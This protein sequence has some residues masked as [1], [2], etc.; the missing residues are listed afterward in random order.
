M[1][2][3]YV[4][5]HAVV[6]DMHG[7][8][9]VLHVGVALRAAHYGGDSLHREHVTIS[10]AVV[11]LIAQV[12]IVVKLL[13]CRGRHLACLIR[14]AVLEVLY[15][16]GLQYD[17][18]GGEALLAVYHLVLAL[19]ALVCHQRA[20]VVRA[21]GMLSEGVVHVLYQCRNLVLLPCVVALIYGYGVCL[22]VLALDVD[23]IYRLLFER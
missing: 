14:Q 6:Y 4:F 5:G 16:E 15:A 7:M 1:V 3:V 23:L 21:L 19:I 12:G 11:Y 18:Y 10:Y 20:Y 8:E 17:V 13:D 22:C 2:E 9:E